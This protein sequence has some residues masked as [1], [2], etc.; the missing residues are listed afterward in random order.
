MKSQCDQNG[1]HDCL[2]AHMSRRYELS[3][4]SWEL[5]KV[6]VSPQQ[7][8]GHRRSEDRFVLSGIL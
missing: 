6:L 4:A 3:D 1:R 8:T 5:I 7:I 2:E